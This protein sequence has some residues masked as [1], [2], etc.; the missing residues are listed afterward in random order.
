MERNPIMGMHI[1]KL[2]TMMANHAPSI[3]AFQIHQVVLM[4]QVKRARYINPKNFNPD[5]FFC[6]IMNN[7]MKAK[8]MATVMLLMGHATKNNKPER[9]DSKID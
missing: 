2:L 7:G 1:N 9:S 4:F 5:S 8:K 3:S 6:S